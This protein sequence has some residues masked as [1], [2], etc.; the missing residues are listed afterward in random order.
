MYQVFGQYSSDPIFEGSKNQ[1]R[2]FLQAKVGG[3]LR[4][5]YGHDWKDERDVFC[6]CT[7][8]DKEFNVKKV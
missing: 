3:R 8:T 6:W 2:K 7:Q 1:C 5:A 4:K